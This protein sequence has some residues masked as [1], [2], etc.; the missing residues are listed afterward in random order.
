MEVIVQTQCQLL[1][2]VQ[3]YCVVACLAFNIQGVPEKTV[4]YSFAHENFEPFAIE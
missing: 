2:V 3:S 1:C 4:A